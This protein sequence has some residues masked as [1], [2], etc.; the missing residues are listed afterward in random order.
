MVKEGIIVVKERVRI[1]MFMMFVVV[2][3]I[4]MVN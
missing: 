4:L 3:L 1:L 2:H